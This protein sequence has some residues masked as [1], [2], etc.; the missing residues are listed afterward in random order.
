[1]RLFINHFLKNNSININKSALPILYSVLASKYVQQN[2]V[3]IPHSYSNK[4]DKEHMIG[5]LNL[6]YTRKGKICKKY[7]KYVKI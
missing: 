1:M 4:Y 3:L 2:S 6:L 5:T 7:N